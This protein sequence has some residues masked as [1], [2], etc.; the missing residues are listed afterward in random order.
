MK[1]IKII[2]HIEICF[3]YLLTS[4]EFTEFEDSKE[5]LKLL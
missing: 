5:G 4:L 3:N 1:L 2:F